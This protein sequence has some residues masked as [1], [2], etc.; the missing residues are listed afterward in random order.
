[1]VVYNGEIYYISGYGKTEDGKYMAVP[2]G[3]STSPVM[4]PAKLARRKVA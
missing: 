3:K 2:V 1:L 4:I